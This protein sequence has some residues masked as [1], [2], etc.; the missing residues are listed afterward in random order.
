MDNNRGI[1]LVVVL[2]VTLMVMILGATAIKMSELGYLAYGSDKRYQIANAAAEYALNTGIVNT[3]ALTASGACP[4][5]AS[6]TL[7][8]GGVNAAYNYFSVSAGNKCF[9]QGTGTFGTAKIVKNVIIPAGDPGLSSYGAMTMRNGGSLAMGGSASIVSCD[10][11]ATPGIMYGGSQTITGT[12]NITNTATCPNNPKGIFGSPFA[13][14]NKTAN[15]C[16]VNGSVISCPSSAPMDDLVP[17]VFK[18]T[19]WTDLVNDLGG[20]YNGHTVDVTNLGIGSSTPMPTMPTAPTIPSGCTCTSAVT[21]SS[22]TSSC[23]GITNWAACGGNIAFASTVTVQGIPSTVT[24]IVS[25]G[26]VTINL[27]SDTTLAGKGIYTT[28]SA[29]ISVS[30]TSKALILDGSTLSAGGT[31][32]YNGMDD[33]KVNNGSILASGEKMDLNDAISKIN[34]SSQAGATVKLITGGD[35]DLQTRDGL[36]KADIIATGANSV[37]N[38]IGAHSNDSVNNA[39]VVTSG[40]NGNINLQGG[41]LAS[42]TVVTK[43]TF[44]SGSITSNVSD[45]NVF[46]KDIVLTQT[47]KDILGGILYSQNTTSTTGNGNGEIGTVA[48]PTLLLSGGNLTLG[49]SGTTNFNGMMFAN[50]TVN[51]SST[52]NFN[53]SGAFIGNSETG[54]NVVNSSGN[55][56]ISFNSAILTTLANNRSTI[57]NA[58]TCG[59]TQAIKRQAYISSTK[60]TVY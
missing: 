58:F 55:Q 25:D 48:N 31:L 5:A 35:L 52:G 21:L 50:G 59:G 22:T 2:A 28:G 3:Y 54:S 32:T 15:N 51:Y 47:N 33:H 17:K 18:S 29:S 45:T 19:N 11:C 44:T 39:M 4:S 56:S 46:A 41:Y 16:S 34:D 1:I 26:N 53:L 36:W 42:S 6:G 7:S 49:H 38:I 10:T 14:V 13:V 57:M 30:S 43:G 12:T 24:N 8:T 23:T 27:G 9:I 40:D 37:I 60:M 20:T